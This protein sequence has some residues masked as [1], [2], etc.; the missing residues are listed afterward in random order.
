MTAR[1]TPTKYTKKLSRSR[2]YRPQNDKIVIGDNEYGINEIIE[3]IC[4]S[5]NMVMHIRYRNLDNGAGVCLFCL[6]PFAF[7]DVRRK[8]KLQTPHRNTNTLISYAPE[9][10]YKDVAIK[11]ELDLQWGAKSLS[12]KGTIRFTSYEER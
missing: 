9:P 10:D 1:A 5:C 8:G 7:P 12:Q 6:E 4:P 3:C 2:S 11:K